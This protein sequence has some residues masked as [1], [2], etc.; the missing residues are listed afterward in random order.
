MQHV[1]LI[2]DTPNKNNRLYRTEVIEKA[3]PAAKELIKEE[4][5]VITSDEPY[6]I[7]SINDIVAEVKDIFIDGIR[8]VIDFEFLKNP[9]A[10]AV[11]EELN[12]GAVSV[13]SNGY[14]T[15]RWDD[16]KGVYIVDDN[17]QITCFSFTRDPS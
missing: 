2:L 9:L 10:N 5:L 17:Y 13:R 7:V 8:L 11:Q 1:A 14:G 16:D 3:L 12:R 6:H 4:R 15:L